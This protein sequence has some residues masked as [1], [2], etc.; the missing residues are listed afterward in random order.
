MSTLRRASGDQLD[1]PTLYAL[2]RLR[3][4][5]FVVEQESPYS[6]LDGRD[7]DPATRHLWFADADGEPLSYLRLLLEPD[8]RTIRVGRVVTRPDARGKGLSRELMREALADIGD[9]P[10]V[11]DAQTTVTRFYASF[12]YRVTGEEYLDAG[13]PHQP[14]ARP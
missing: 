14:M 4:D 5:V 1:A 8:G 9:A 11:L 7:L 2:L 3:V 12:G 13:V 10:S 6:D